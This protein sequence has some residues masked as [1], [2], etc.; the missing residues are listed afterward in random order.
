VRL[1][2]DHREAVRSQYALTGLMAT[3]TIVTLWLLS[4]PL[5]A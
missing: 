3:Y 1:A 4:R 2:A 5:V